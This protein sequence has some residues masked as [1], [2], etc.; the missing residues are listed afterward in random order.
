MPAMTFKQK[1]YLLCGLGAF[2][3][4]TV[5]GV[6]YY[7]QV[8]LGETQENNRIMAEA[9]RHHLEADM[10]HD[11]L[12]GDML[13]ALLA[14]SQGQKDLQDTL[15][16]EFQEHAASFRENIKENQALPLQPGIQGKLQEVT[17]ALEQYISDSQNIITLAFTDLDAAK[18]SQPAFTASFSRLE[19]E[20]ESIS[21]DISAEMATQ[22]KAAQELQS[23][24]AFLSLGV[25]AVFTTLIVV[26]GAAIIRG[27]LRQ[28][29]GDPAYA[30]H[31]VGRVARGELDIHVE[32]EA[33]DEHSLLSA[34]DD[35]RIKLKN[36]IEEIT[37][38]GEQQRLVAQEASRV[39]QALDVCSTAAM[40]S[41]SQGNVIY[42]NQSLGYLFART[43]QQISHHAPGLNVARLTEWNV[44]ALLDLHGSP[45]RGLRS[46]KQQRLVIDELTFDITMT[47][48]MAENADIIGYVLEWQDQTEILANQQAEQRIAQENARVRQALDN[49]SSNTM[50]AD[51]QGNIVYMNKAVLEM[52]RSAETD[53]RKDLPHFNANKLLGA[54]FDLFHKNPSHQR[55]LLATLT[56]TYQTRISV[57]GRIFSLIANPIISDKQERIGTVVQWNDRTQEV[58]IENE[59]NDLLA[60][61]NEGDLGK[62]IDLHNKE[63]FYRTLSEGLNNLVGVADNV[64][65][66]AS[67]VM[68][69]LAHGRL[70]ERIEAE[71]SGMFDKLK[72]DTNATV[73]RLVSVVEQIADAARAVSNGAEEIAQGNA[74]LS[75]RTEEQASSLEETASSM[76][77]MTST[78]RQSSENAKNAN[79]LA[80]EARERASRGGE[81]VAR[82]VTAMGAISTSSKKIA[83][84]ISVIDE[85]AFQTNLLALNAAVEAARA[86]EQG[87]GFAVVA[88][89]VRSLAQRSA[90]AAKEIKDLI[91]DSVSKVQDGTL[92]VN[93][94][95]DTLKELV[96]S[97]QKVSSIVQEI[98]TAAVEQTAGIEQVNTA[99]SQMDEMTQQNAALVEEAS[100]AGEALSEQARHLLE[101][102]TFFDIG[103]NVA[104]QAGIGMSRQNVRPARPEH[105]HASAT[106]VRTA[107]RVAPKPVHNGGHEDDDGAQW[108]EF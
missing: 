63:G 51:N 32:R 86:G 93:E 28:L 13:S 21:N 96:G 78:V 89:E 87:R 41:D 23:F 97:V 24:F 47:P 60:A 75:Q 8:R 102:I 36:N 59:L 5:G 43:G 15:V 66:D 30:A 38:N 19:E 54:N 46:A 27:L 94:S 37:R 62:R 18:A 31:I 105:K 1:M 45:L 50:I 3:A 4:M 52:M 74:D 103:R 65:S 33:G 14:A 53:L 16:T 68:D 81:V 6:G 91:R 69:A 71:Y 77:E 26:V 70:D 10:M 44:N 22:Q 25:I 82:A 92:L 49:V 84:I 12:R 48:V 104:A 9:Q 90:S 39:K 85:I 88:G 20:M 67:R 17:P 95:G 40:I 35:M 56:K 106:K 34:I 64:I 2:S 80:V 42:H 83:D 57:A 7:E 29:G 107:S 99:V 55:N 101:L 72:Q 61:A 11:A 73:D 58:A 98:A 108:E 79:A 76:E 100:A